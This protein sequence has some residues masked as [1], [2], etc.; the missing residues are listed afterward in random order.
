MLR[1]SFQRIAEIQ[2]SQLNRYAVNLQ[3]GFYAV[4]KPCFES[5]NRI[6]SQ[7]RNYLKEMKTLN[8]T[9]KQ[10]FIKELKMLEVR[11]LA[12]K[13]YEHAFQLYCMATLDYHWTEYPS[14][15]DLIPYQLS[16]PLHALSSALERP[17]ILGLPS[18]QIHNWKP[19]H[20]NLPISIS[21]IDMEYTFTESSDEKYFYAIAAL[22]DMQ[23]APIIEAI[24]N[25]YSSLDH[26]DYSTI[27]SSLQAIQVS[28]KKMKLSLSYNY[29]YVSPH[30]F[31]NTIRTKLKS[32]SPS[33]QFQHLNIPTQPYFGPSAIQSPM[34]RF[35]DYALDLSHSRSEIDSILP[36]LK[37]QHRNFL[38]DIRSQSCGLRSFIIQASCSDEWND[39]IEELADFRRKHILL[40]SHYISKFSGSEKGTGSSNF[41]DLLNS[42]ISSTLSYKI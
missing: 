14:S 41:Q 34:I 36:Y 4:D 15:V 12:E 1:S 31:Y 40:T 30:Y 27:P 28:L 10:K 35:I 8:L 20:S 2:S 18:T 42:V 17:A 6:V 38:Y 33:I 7:V 19:I 16:I 37:K 23:G 11:E 21:N 13:E 24:L 25:I 22:I 9:Q 29:T 3:N 5:D 26:Q 39:L 32:Y